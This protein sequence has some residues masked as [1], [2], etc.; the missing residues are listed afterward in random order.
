MLNLD[1]LKA[2][3]RC[4]AVTG[5]VDAVNRAVGLMHDYLVAR[6]LHCSVETMGERRVLYAATEEGRIPAV[7]LNA[8]L[9][10]VPAPDCMFEP[11][12]RDGRLY[13]RGAADCQ[14]NA[15]VV[16]EVLCGLVGKAS[17]GA[18]FSTD[19]ETGGATTACMMKRG[20]G[21]GKLVLILDAAPYGI[22]NAQKGILSLVLRA[23]GRG[24]HSSEPWSFVNPIDLLIDGYAKLRAAWPALPADHWGDTM[25]PCII[26]GG[27]AFNQIPDTAQMVL[28]IRFIHP[29]DE[30]RIIGM[31]RDATGLEVAVESAHSSV[32]VFVDES[33]PLM[34]ELQSAMQRHFTGHRVG[35]Y[36]MHGA[37]DARHMASLGV[38]V[39]ILG[40][41]GGGA[42]SSGE[43]VCLANLE[44]NRSFLTDFIRQIG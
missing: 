18:I 17:A 11:E 33:H 26:S 28:N 35:F 2:L 22:A 13:A 40:S 43:W 19:E 32:P 16:A 5:D 8:H 6:G 38:P 41:E 23:N 14:G 21:A 42:H 20:Y 29:G 36:R 9:D 39:A 25:A 1:L 31:V 3:I 37:T 44:A 10:V 27:Q 15:L 7:L 24:G 34:Q 4:K 30:D 12:E